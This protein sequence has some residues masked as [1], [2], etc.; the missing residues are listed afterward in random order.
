MLDNDPPQAVIE[1][2]HSVFWDTV[3]SWIYTY[4]SNHTGD[5]DNTALGFLNK[6]EHTQGHSNDP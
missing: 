3:W 5:I 1:R 2:L 4:S 6:G